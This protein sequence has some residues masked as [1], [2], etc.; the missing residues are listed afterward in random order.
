MLFT[1]Q[2]PLDG[3]FL[4]LED[5]CI[6]YSDALIN[7][8]PLVCLSIHIALVTEADIYQCID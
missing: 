7:L 4:F 6:Q 5:I 3:A 2:V 8:I 1:S